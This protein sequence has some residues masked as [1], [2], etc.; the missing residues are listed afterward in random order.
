MEPGDVFAL[1]MQRIETVEVMQRTQVKAQRGAELRTWGLK[2]VPVDP[3][4]SLAADDRDFMTEY[5][6]AM[7]ST[8]ARFPIM[9]AVDCLEAVAELIEWR[10]KSRNSHAASILALCRTATE[11]AATTIWLLSSVDR[12]MRRGLSVRFANSEIRPQLRYHAS[13]NKW[14]AADPARLE[15]QL[16][17][18]FREH[19]R[20]Y[21]EK[22]AMLR[23]G[24]Q[25]T[26]NGTV[27]SNDAVVR[28]AAQWIDRHPPWH[29]KPD[30]GPYGNSRFGFEDVATS[31]YTVSSAIIHGL[32]WPLDYM[33]DGELDMSRM[34]VEGVN[35]AVAMAEC[36]VALFEAQAQQHLPRFDQERHY[37]KRLAPT[38]KVWSAEY[39][40]HPLIEPHC[41]RI[42]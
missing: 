31:F 40:V 12:A 1:F 6:A 20:L 29:A 18:D 5:H 32:K 22:A 9:N 13:T 21:E 19:V 36:G 41:L 10:P 39:P 14:L 37:P 2:P 7:V 35:V 16:H 34:V 23:R 30:R 3:G 28:A 15:S 27:K 25:A 11:S 24:E 42:S 38:I 4:S 26:P 8:T 33:P 17:N